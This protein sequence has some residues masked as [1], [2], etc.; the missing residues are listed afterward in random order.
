M[1]KTLTLVMTL[2]VLFGAFV[3][4]VPAVYAEDASQADNGGIDKSCAGQTITVFNWGEYISDGSDDSMKVIE[5]FTKETGINVNYTM[6]T[7]NEDLYALLTGGG[8]TYDVIVPSDYMFERLLAEGYLAPIDFSNV[9]NYANI[10]EKYKNCFDYINDKKSA[11]EDGYKEISEDAN[12]YCVPYTIGM[13][14]VIYDSEKVKDVPQNWDLLWDEKYKGEILMF[15]NPRDAFAI[16]QFKLGMDINTTNKEDWK[17]AAEELK[18][19]KEVLKGYANDEIFDS[20]ENGY[21]SI[22]VYYAGDFLSMQQNNE[23]LAFYYPKNEDGKLI[24][25]QFI[26]VMC[27]TKASKNKKAAEMFINYMLRADIARAN[28]EYIC[29]ASPNKAVVNDPEYCFSKENDPDA[30]AILYPAELNEFDEKLMFRNLP[31]ETINEMNELFLE[32]KSSGANSWVLYVIIGVI[33]VA[34]VVLV[35][36]RQR[37]KKARSLDED[38]N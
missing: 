7:N 4:C 31:K 15:N 24:T 23:K 5:E 26:D 37:K 1:K 21:A 18:K 17:L 9:P 34:L 27:V 16:A 14:G 8:N 32:V 36:V 25:N 30:Y 13:V 29:Y 10:D 20:M 19:Q 11:G 6:Y 35:V 28:A 2:V 3:F 22:G 12:K 33:V 38:Y